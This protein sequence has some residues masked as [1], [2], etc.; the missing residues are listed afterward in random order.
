[1]LR[2]SIPGAVT[3]SDERMTSFRTFLEALGET[4]ANSGVRIRVLSGDSEEQIV[5]SI[6]SLL[7]IDK[8]TAVVAS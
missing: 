6:V 2:S 4:Q 3:I 8:K 7:L 5:D 1:V